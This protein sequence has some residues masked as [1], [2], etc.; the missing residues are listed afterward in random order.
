M[1]VSLTERVTAFITGVIALG[2]FGILLS[3]P[4]VIVAYIVKVVLG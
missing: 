1:K 2:V 4:V 3:I